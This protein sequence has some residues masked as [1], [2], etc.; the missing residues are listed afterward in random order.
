VAP[1]ITPQLMAAIT[2]ILQVNGPSGRYLFLVEATG[3]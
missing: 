2:P 1:D 3:S